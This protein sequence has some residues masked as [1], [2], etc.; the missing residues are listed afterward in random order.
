MSPEYELWRCPHCGRDT[1]ITEE[2]RIT[3]GKTIDIANR[4]EFSRISFDLRVCPNKQCQAASITVTLWTR[5]N[6]MLLER[7]AGT[8]PLV[9]EAF[10]DELPDVVPE[11]IRKDYR[12]ATLILRFSPKAAATLA[13]R[14]VQGMIRDFYNIKERTLNEE[15]QKLKDV[16][17]PD[18]CEP[19][20]RV[21]G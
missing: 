13:R 20:M 2:R 14:A 12:E 9:P 16:V 11:H 21:G 8:W 5:D 1:T 10:G 18:T 15:V 19:S 7:P 17:D 3:Y 4:Q 6:T